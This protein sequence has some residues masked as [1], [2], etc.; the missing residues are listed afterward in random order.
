MP[1][2][3][4]GGTRILPSKGGVSVSELP[5]NREWI[6]WGRHDPLYAVT[7]RPGKEMGGPAPWTPEEFLEVGRLYFADVYR[8]WQ[9][10]GVGSE[11]CVEIGCGSGRITRQ[12]ISRFRRVTALDVS[13]EQLQN[14]RRLLGAS[15]SGVALTLVSEP[16]L[17]LPNVSCDAVFSCEVFQHVDTHQ[18]IADYLR[19]AHRVLVPGGTVCFQLPVRGVHRS[20]FLSSR[21]RTAMLRLLRRLGRRRMMIYRQYPADLVFRLLT[22]AKFQNLE[23]RLFQAAQH[24]GFVAYFFGRKL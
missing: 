13:V 23:M 19:E 24:E 8:H 9:Q 15:A 7:T 10:Y 6:F 11:H 17:P 5:S 4:L 18:P 16:I 22:D 3:G 21:A 12:L 1:P 20:S 2:F 14:A